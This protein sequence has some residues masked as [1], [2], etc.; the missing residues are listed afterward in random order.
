ME[1]KINESRVLEQRL[2]DITEGNGWLEYKFYPSKNAIIHIISIPQECYNQYNKG[3]IATKSL[4]LYC[5]SSRILRV[6]W[7]PH[8]M[9]NFVSMKKGFPCF[10][11]GQKN[12]SS[13]GHSTSFP[14][15]GMKMEEQQLKLESKR[16]EETRWIC[17]SMRSWRS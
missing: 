1:C 9:K 5:S 3:Q 4:S 14:G 8:T 10:N 7:K 6:L 11:L 13:W 17:A 15:T 16:R 12:T 2:A